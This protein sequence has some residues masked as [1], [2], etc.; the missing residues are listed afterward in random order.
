MFAQIILIVTQTAPIWV[1]FIIAMLFWH[2]WLN[3][4]R[5]E[6]I[7]KQE[8]V[9]LKIKL[10]KEQV[11][12]PLAMELFLTTLHQMSGE[13]NWY[14][15][16]WLGKTR[17]WFSLEMASIEG[18][19]N[20]YIWTRKPLV[21]FIES[22]LYAQFPG[23]EVHAATD[24]AIPVQY[25][26]KTMK[27]WAAELQFTKDDAYPIKTYID[28]GL[29]K[30][31]KEEYKVDPIAPVIEYLG[32]IGANQQAWMQLI[33]RGYRPDYQ[34][35]GSIFKFKKDVLKEK[36]DKV[37]SEILLRDTKTKIAGNPEEGSS[38]NPVITKGE[39]EIV[40]SIERNA[41]KIH[42]ETGIRIGYFAKSEFF[43][44]GNIAGLT[45]SWK[46]YS[47]NAL[48][49]FKPYDDHYSPYFKYPWQDFRGIRMTKE[50]KSWIESYK[51]RNFFFAPAD[52]YKMLLM[53]IEELATVFHF[54]GQAAASPALNRVLSKKSEAPANLPI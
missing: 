45:G 28:Y 7:F 22:S 1:T 44:P 54:P 48:N 40:A 29:D 51:R 15:R 47:S 21:N 18:E 19:V 11:K 38:K 41:S 50:L 26:P 12:S 24:Y 27:M 33:I 9:L 32:S 25:D 39:Q 16:F 13:G 4:V 53:S 10:P 36:A 14:D 2:V 52:G 35:T 6:F 42:F 46:Q 8:H 3:Y 43:N 17:A 49:G 5:S 31:Q 23:I 37:I 20:F 30:D 34:N